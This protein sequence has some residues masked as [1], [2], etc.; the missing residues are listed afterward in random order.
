MSCAAR[1]GAISILLL[2]CFPA[3]AA[4]EIRQGMPLNEYIELLQRQGLRVIYSSDLVLDEYLLRQVPAASDPAIALREAL[5]PYGLNLADGPAGSLLVTRGERAPPPVIAESPEVDEESLPEP[6]PEIVVTAS[7]YDIRYEQSGSHNFLDRDLATKM[8]DLGD[9]ALRAIARLPGTSGG[10]ISTRNHVRGG[11][12]NEQLFLLD[13]LRLYEPYHM[14]DFHSIATIVD[15]NVIAGIDFYSAGYQARYGDRMSGVVDISLREPPA[16]TETELSLSFFN[17]SAMSRGRFG[18]NDNGDWLVSGRRANLDLLA[19]IVNPDYGSPRYQDYLVHIGWNLDRHYLSANGLFAYDKI[20][21][22]EADDSEHANAKYTNDILWLKA[23][24]EWT[25]RIRSSTIL[26]ATEIENQ[27][28]GTTDKPGVIAGTVDDEREFRSLALKQDWQFDLAGRWLL[29]SG[30][31]LKRLEADYRYSASLQIF[32]PFDQILD[33]QPSESREVAI[34]PRGSQYAAYA[35]L[36]WRPSDRLT[37]DAGL[38]W[39]QQTY[40]TA[41]DDEQVSPRVNLL[42][43]AGNGTEL[44]LAFG[45]YYQAQ[46]INELQVSDGLTDFHPAQR[47]QHLVAS[48]VHSFDAGV[49][50]R[51]E[52]YQKKY[53][54]LMPR[55]ENI[56]DSLVLIPEL[57]IDRARIDADNAAAEGLEV[58]LTG[59]GANNLSWWASYSW[60]RAA[61]TIDGET[62]RRSWDQTHTISAGLSRDWGNWSASAA[63]L[64]HTG[65]PKSL[66][67]TETITN[68]D[69]STSLIAEVDPADGRR[70]AMFQSLDV[71]ISRR[72]DLPKGDLTAFLEITNAYN[73][74]NPCCTEYTVDLDADG[75]AFVQAKGGAWLPIVPSLGVVWRF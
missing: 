59:G 62:S 56:F 54:Y 48:L 55:F 47:A 64:L 35:E 57:Q 24:S 51:L 10:G 1:L 67:V 46:E 69:G 4:D 33:N 5:A 30:F 32:P 17:T 29:S 21:V 39:D 18:G 38:R 75:D 58:S 20:S 23:D 61:D 22:S 40:T 63:A 13:G 72:F 9:E 44:R 68:P 15:Q 8:P 31:E 49:E 3:V 6:L 2:L 7:R 50:L 36:R 65:W 70:H 27:R 45:E 41:D 74:E 71:R 25:D 66:L 60:S 34:A 11:L 26:S 19:D 16:G 43:K 14:K 12:Q 42:Y 37:L 73:R 28:S 52:A 53:S